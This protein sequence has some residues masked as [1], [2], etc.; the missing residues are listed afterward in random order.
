MTVTM[1]LLCMLG[2]GLLTVLMLYSKIIRYAVIAIAISV[3]GTVLKGWAMVTLWAWFVI[4]AFGL[5]ALT[6]PVAIGLGFL[7]HLFQ[8]ID[9][10]SIEAHQDKDPN[11]LMKS[12]KSFMFA[13][14]FPLF[15][16]GGGWLVKL[17]M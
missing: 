13:T 1:W 5:Q 15:S 11:L 12:I 8:Y 6:M 10:N 7:L 9:F 4:P 16:V 3:Y 14:L 2:T 17:F